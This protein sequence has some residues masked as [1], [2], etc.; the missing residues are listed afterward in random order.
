MDYIPPLL[1]RVKEYSVYGQVTI[2][3]H[4]EYS[5]IE[6]LCYQNKL[7][8][9]FVNVILTLHDGT[10][11]RY[12]NDHSILENIKMEGPARQAYYAAIE[13]THEERQQGRII[14]IRF[15]SHK[16]EEIVA[17]IAAGQ[18]TYDNKMPMYRPT[19]Y[20]KHRE[21]PVGFSFASRRLSGRSFVTIN[22]RRYGLAPRREV[23]GLGFGHK[24]RI[25]DHYTR[26]NLMAP[27]ERLEIKAAPAKL[28]VGEVWRYAAGK[29]TLEYVIE[30]VEEG[31]L[32]LRRGKEV[33]KVV[34]KEGQMSLSSMSSYDDSQE[35]IIM[36]FVP[37]L[38]ICPHTVKQPSRMTV[39][40]NETVIYEAT[41]YNQFD[42]EANLYNFVGDKGY[43]AIDSNI[44]YDQ[45]L[46]GNWVLTNIITE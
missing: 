9:M 31:L 25:A 1:M 36:N 40:S 7:G 33:H 45:R 16:N 21:L 20:V 44:H 6:V 24:G 35:L 3:D 10:S 17:L 26:L 23:L 37:P 4:R 34:L 43:P 12:I 29:R 46:T 15:H 13:Y 42:G 8:R 27:P 5:C 41:V 39:V 38:P 32:T 2:K 14:R 30:A 22:N 11:V 19:G 18:P 28:K